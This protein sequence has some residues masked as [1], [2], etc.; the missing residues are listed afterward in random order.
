MYDILIIGAGPAGLTAAIYGIRAGMSV[1]V[2]EA[3]MYGGQIAGT[4]E[5]ENYPS[6]Q[7]ISGWQLAQNIYEQAAAQGAEIRFEGV[8]GIKEDENGI[9]TVITSG[10]RY[11]SKTVIIANGAKR[12]L[13]GCP[14][15]EEFKGRGVSYCATCDG[16]FFRGKVTA[17]V[18]G[19]NTAL[20]D[21]LFLSNLCEKVYLIVRKDRFRGEK[22]LADSVQARENIEVLYSHVVDSI[23][24]ED[25]VSSVKVKNG[26]GVIREIPVSAVFVAIGMEPDNGLFADFVDIDEAGYII[27][28]ES[29]RTSRNGVF[30]AG[31][32]RTKEVRQIITAAADGAAAAIAAA[33][34][35]NESAV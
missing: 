13:L 17:V 34:L 20:E 29:C 32:S 26:D 4:P 24:G 15:E 23:E 28:G 25:L 19:G 10:G 8:T 12:R 7:K 27:A 1:L 30:A 35:V 22:R 5:V 14:G 2:L 18:G 6:I 3:M 9:K 33:N 31:D 21:S 16:A 11:E